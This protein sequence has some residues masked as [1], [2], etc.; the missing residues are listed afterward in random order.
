MLKSMIFVTPT[1]IRTTLGLISPAS[2]YS[3]SLGSIT[4]LI[5]NTVDAIDTRDRFKKRHHDSS[6]MVAMSSYNNNNEDSNKFT[7]TAIAAPTISAAT[8]N[9]HRP[10]KVMGMQ[11]CF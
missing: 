6:V 10:M 4:P 8:Q 1:C 7:S 9:L 2:L 11:P 5:E 3:R